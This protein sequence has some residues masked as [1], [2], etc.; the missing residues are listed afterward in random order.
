MLIWGCS[1]L[2]VVV[3]HM[4]EAPWQLPYE[5]SE[6]E[7]ARNE[8]LRIRTLRLVAKRLSHSSRRTSCVHQSL[9]SS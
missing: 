4:P 3:G 9:L 6:H 2:L 7:P 1:E 8:V 5:L